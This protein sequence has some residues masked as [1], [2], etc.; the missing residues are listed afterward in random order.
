MGSATND[1]VNE[2]TAVECHSTDKLYEIRCE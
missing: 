2:A 1:V